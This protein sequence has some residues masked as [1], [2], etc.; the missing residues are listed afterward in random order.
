MHH[1]TNIYQTIF[2]QELF[3]LQ[4]TG[5]CLI[6]VRQCLLC[7]TP[8][9]KTCAPDSYQC[10]IILYRCFMRRANTLDIDSNTPLASS[11]LVTFSLVFLCHIPP[12]SYY[13]HHFRKVSLPIR[14]LCFL[15]SNVFPSVSHCSPLQKIVNTSG[16]ESASF[17]PVQPLRQWC[18][19]DL[20]WGGGSGVS[21]Q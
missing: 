11:L 9:Q 1:S 3:H 17:D 7:P 21:D 5:W 2:F 10:G 12:L 16:S 13:C 15:L 18:H 8:Q 14:R 6:T 4:S 19:F 20:F